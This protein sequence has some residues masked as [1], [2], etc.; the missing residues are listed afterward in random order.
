MRYHMYTKNDCNDL[1]EKIANMEMGMPEQQPGGMQPG[2]GGLVA[3]GQD[4]NAAAAGG[5]AA[6]P[7]GPP[8]VKPEQ[9]YERMLKMTGRMADMSAQL[10]Q[11]GQQGQSMEQM[12]REDQQEMQTQNMGMQQPGIDPSMGMGQAP[13]M[14]QGMGMQQPQQGMDFGM[15]GQPGLQPQASLRDWISKSLKKEALLGAHFAAGLSGD[16]LEGGLNIGNRFSRNRKN[17]GNPLNRGHTDMMFHRATKRV[18]TP[19]GR[20][21]G[22]Q[23]IGFPRR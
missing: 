22:S 13:G 14:D 9:L 12:V 4:P 10:G 7:K 15:G 11:A 21:E 8:K 3:D 18:D 16:A 23:R 17:S 19:E 2:S 1:L 6:G 20:F 5:G